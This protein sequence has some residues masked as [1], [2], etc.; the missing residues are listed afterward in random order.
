MQVLFV[1]LVHGTMNTPHD[2][3]KDNFSYQPV[4]TAAAYTVLWVATTATWARA[5]ARGAGLSRTRQNTA[6]CPIRGLRDPATISMEKGG[7]GKE[8]KDGDRRR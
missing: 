4:I 3:L 7:G 5:R 8:K 1:W 6:T 2:R